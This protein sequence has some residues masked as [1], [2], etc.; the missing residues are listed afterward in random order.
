MENG[1][2]DRWAACLGCSFNPGG[3][4]PLVQNCAKTGWG[5]QIW[6]SQVILKLEF[7]NES[8]QIQVLLY[9][10]ESHALPTD[11]DANAIP[12]SFWTDALFVF[13]AAPTNFRDGFRFRIDK[14][15]I[16]LQGVP[17]CAGVVIKRFGSACC[18]VTGLRDVGEGS[19][20]RAM[21][22]RPQ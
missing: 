17:S 22:S 13:P 9:V 14:A 12:R 4:I 21:I 8:K 20:P 11:T 16:H 1:G 15:W 19:M 18:L 10:R 7:E 5:L 3:F 6:I 2:V